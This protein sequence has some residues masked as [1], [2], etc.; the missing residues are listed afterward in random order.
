MRPII[1]AHLDLAYNALAANRDQLLD[2]DAINHAEAALTDDSSRGHATVCLPELRRANVP[3]VVGTLFARSGPAPRPPQPTAK[4]LDADSSTQPIAHAVA[5]GQL[6]Y[7]YL[8]A[9]LGHLRLI[10]T[11]ADLND[12][13]SACTPTPSTPLA[14]PLPSTSPLNPEPRTLHPSPLGL[15]LSMEGADPILSP[16]DLHHWHAQG[17]RIIGPA[18]FGHSHYASGP[19]LDGPIT[20]RGVELL[21]HMHL[22]HMILDVTHLCDTSLNQAL[23]LFPG[24]VIASHHNCRTLAPGPRQLAD[25]QIRRLISRGAVIGVAFYN[26]MLAPNWRPGDPPVP[27]SRVADHIDHLCQLAGSSRHTALGTDLDGGFGST[28]TPSINSH[29]DLHNLAPIL[30]ARG[31]TDSDLDNLFHQNWLRFFRSSL[32]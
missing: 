18:H 19:P 17:L 14:P 31:Y 4:R 15:I 22:L 27:L 23:D 20:A 16:D 30:T 29:S 9:R 1:D 6:A 32:P 8:L 12:H 10:T 28:E 24:P 25:D 26:P 21:Q 11:A 13:W 5:Q 3:L 7:Y 2:L